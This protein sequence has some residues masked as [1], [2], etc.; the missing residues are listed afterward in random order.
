MSQ[1][2][3]GG[4]DQAFTR[5]GN[6]YCFVSPTDRN[7]CVKVLR[8]DRSPE[9]RRAEKR[10]PKN[11]KPVGLFDDNL[12]EFRVYQRIDQSIGEPAYDVIARCYGFVDTDLGRGLSSE[13][14]R[15]DNG[16]I[17][18]TL[19][20]YLWERG[21]DA[22]IEPSLK[23]FCDHWQRHGMPSRNLLLHNIVV[24]QAENSIRRLVVID[25]LGWPGLAPLAYHLP[26]LARYKAA[27]KVK[28]LYGA[29][30]NL[31]NKKRQNSDYGYHGWLTQTQRESI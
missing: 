15:D 22:M 20:Q 5:G 8:P 1:L 27:R 3:L 4:I 9:V 31:L 14:I 2:L 19:K 16:L 6:R 29:I 17:S 13:L 7:V 23:R 10:F 12:A 21:V 24:Q 25:G 30:E 28:N 11:V 18:I 26:A